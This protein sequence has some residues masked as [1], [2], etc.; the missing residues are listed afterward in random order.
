MSFDKVGA[1]TPRVGTNT[2]TP[3]A[4]KTTTPVSMDVSK[5]SSNVSKNET[6]DQESDSYQCEQDQECNGDE[7]FAANGKGK[8]GLTGNCSSSSE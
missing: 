3:T 7:L 2:N 1:V 5:M 8:G 6:E 4:A